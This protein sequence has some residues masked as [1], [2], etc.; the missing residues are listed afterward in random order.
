MERLLGDHHEG[1]AGEEEE[2]GG[3]G[4][5]TD[6]QGQGSRQARVQA[7]KVNRDFFRPRKAATDP[8]ASQKEKWVAAETRENK[9]S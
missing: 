7:Q 6:G 2:M 9:R 1:K 3:E 8:A 5:V 4:G